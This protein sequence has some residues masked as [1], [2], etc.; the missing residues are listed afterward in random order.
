MGIGKM[1]ED[2]RKEMRSAFREAVNMAPQELERW[3]DT[4]ASRSVGW[5]RQGEDE[6]VGRP[7]GRRIVR[8]DTRS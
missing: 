4:D 8:L 1:T 7:S 2:E 6:S 3:L 5:T